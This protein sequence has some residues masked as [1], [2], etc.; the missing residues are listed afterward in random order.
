M[1]VNVSIENDKCIP[2]KKHN[3]DAGFDLRSAMEFFDIYPGETKQIH[4]GTR[5]AIPEGYMGMIVPRSGLGSRGFALK[6]TVGIIDSDY[7]GEI[8]IIG[9]NNGISPIPINKFDRI[10]QLILIPV[11]LPILNVVSN[12]D[13]TERG[14]GGFG[15]TGHN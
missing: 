1:I 9:T 6:N 14:E 7:R 3:N 11:L 12:L 8:I 15:H 2:Y 5:I 4:T 10:A 13:D